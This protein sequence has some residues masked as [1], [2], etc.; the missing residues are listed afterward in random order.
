VWCLESAEEEVN[1]IGKILQASQL[2]DF[3]DATS[4]FT[5]LAHSSN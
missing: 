1:Y 4:K 3:K 2:W 5:E